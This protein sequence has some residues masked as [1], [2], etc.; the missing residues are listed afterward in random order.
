MGVVAVRE[1]K[2]AISKQVVSMA[3]RITSGVTRSTTGTVTV[4]VLPVSG[5]SREFQVQAG[6]A[7][8]EVGRDVVVASRSGGTVL[9][10]RDPDVG[11]P[12]KGAL[13]GDPGLGPGQGSPGTGVDAVAEGHVLSCIGPIHPELGGTFELPGVVVGATGGHECRRPG[14]DVDAT[15]GRREARQS[16]GSLYGTLDPQ[17]LLDEVGD[18]LAVVSEQLLEIGA[19]SQQSQRCGEEPY[20]RLLS[21]G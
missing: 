16:E 20:R 15:H 10:F 6:Q 13:E 1:T 11:R 9:R 18:A 2:V 19:L 14:W 5:R 7:L 12:V 21:G 4:M 3:E 17:G 8:E